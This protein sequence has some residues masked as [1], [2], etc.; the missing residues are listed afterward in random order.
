MFNKLYFNSNKKI[1]DKCLSG[2]NKKFCTVL[3]SDEITPKDIL[4][5]LIYIMQTVEKY[6]IDGSTKKDIAVNALKNIVSKYGNNI[7]N[8]QHVN[9]FIDNILYSLID[10]I[11]LVDRKEI[12][13][14]LQNAI[15]TCLNI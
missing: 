2:I 12:N 7:K 3:K 4:N 1:I 15:H 13:I 9:A 6:K 11:I 14:K 10:V 8:I 5:F